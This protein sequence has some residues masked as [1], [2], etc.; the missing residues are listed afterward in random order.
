MYKFIVWCI[1][2]AILNEFIVFKLNYQ[3]V[4]ALLANVSFAEKKQNLHVHTSFGHAQFL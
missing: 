4:T 1:Q 2:G 3:T